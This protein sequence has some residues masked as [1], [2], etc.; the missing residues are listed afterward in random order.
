MSASIRLDKVSVNFRIYRNP[1]PSLKDSA[2]N[3]VTGNR[4]LNEYKDFFALHEIDLTINSG[5]RVG[6]IGMNGAG[7]STLLKTISSIYEPH[8]GRIVVE[9][10]ITPLMELG[11]GFNREQTG[12][13]NIYLNGALLG[14]SPAEMREREREIAEFSELEDFLDLPV[15]YYSS[16]MFGRLAFS[17]AASTDPD[18]LMIDEV[19]ST[20]D[21]HFVEKSTHRIQQMVEKSNILMV[22][23]HNLQH[24]RRLSNRV[25]FLDH[26]KIIGDGDPDEIIAQY[27]QKLTSIK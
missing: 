13:K 21:G 12:R 25:I 15:K 3:W 2:V 23:S 24:I 22:V 16:G 18:I 20:G 8:Q 4:K 6:L 19:F 1:S 17:I 7:K 14:F 26:G 11:A 27:R 10:R 9:G 5:D